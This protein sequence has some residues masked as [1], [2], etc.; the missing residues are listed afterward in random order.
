MHSNLAP[1]FF[2]RPRSSATCYLTQPQP[3][4]LGQID[5]AHPASSQQRDDAVMADLQAD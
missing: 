3:G 2:W 5:F 1:S 4:V